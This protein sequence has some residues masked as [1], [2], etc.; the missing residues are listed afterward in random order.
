M[1]GRAGLWVGIQAVGQAGILSQTYIYLI[2]KFARIQNL[3]KPEI[4]LDLTFA[5]VEFGFF[6]AIF[7]KFQIGANFAKVQ[8]DGQSVG[9]AGGR[10]GV[11]LFRLAFGWAGVLA[12]WR[13]GWH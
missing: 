12:G 8:A 10:A 5:N 4:C 2:S 1:G 3:P 13:L 11:W 6:L 9:W 7:I